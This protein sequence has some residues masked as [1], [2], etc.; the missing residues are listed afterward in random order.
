MYYDCVLRRAQTPE[1]IKSL[2]L[3]LIMSSISNQQFDNNTYRYKWH[4]RK[5]RLLFWIV[6]LVCLSEYITEL[7]SDWLSNINVSILFIN[8]YIL[9]GGVIY[10]VF[11]NFCILSVLHYKRML[12]FWW[13][14]IISVTQTLI[15]LFTF[16]RSF[17]FFK[18]SVSEFVFKCYLFTV[19]QRL[20]VKTRCGKCRGW[21]HVSV[22]TNGGLHVRFFLQVLFAHENTSNKPP[23]RALHCFKPTMTGNVAG[24]H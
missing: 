22:P 17:L 6:N 8:C 7:V 1:N 4:Y 13:F 9:G 10:C 21:L 16:L 5:L 2:I 11:K 12:L 23:D 24:E 18:T 14:V 15:I 3:A 20:P 19:W